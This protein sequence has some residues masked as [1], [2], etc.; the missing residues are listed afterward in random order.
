MALICL[1]VSGGTT[2]VHTD[3]IGSMLQFHAGTSTVTQG[4]VV[5]APDFCLACEWENTLFSPQVPVVP[6]V[7]P[8]LTLL[9]VLRAE[10]QTR[11]PDPFD[12]TS[13]RAPP[14]IFS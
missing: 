6:I 1:G 5:A 3:D 13:S 10:V 9:P 4:G 7:H 8:I 2:L 14:R 12:H 11:Y